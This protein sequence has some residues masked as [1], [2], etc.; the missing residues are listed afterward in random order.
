MTTSRKR[1]S[2]TSR[3][4]SGPALWSTGE[5]GRR[6]RMTR[7]KRM[8]REEEGVKETEEEE[9]CNLGEMKTQQNI[10]LAISGNARESSCTGEKHS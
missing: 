2:S 1:S 4:D 8:R 9:K 10:Y 7:E 6:R 5:R 3:A